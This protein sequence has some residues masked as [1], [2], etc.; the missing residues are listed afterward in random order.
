MPYRPPTGA[1]RPPGTPWISRNTSRQR[2][3]RG[4]KA[5]RF[6]LHRAGLPIRCGSSLP[7]NT[8]G[9]VWRRMSFSTCSAGALPGPDFCFIFAPYGYDEPETFPSESPSIC[10][11]GADGKQSHTIQLGRGKPHGAD[12]D[13]NRGKKSNDACLLGKRRCVS[14]HSKP[15]RIPAQWVRNRDFSSS[16]SSRSAR[17]IS[18]RTGHHWSNFRYFSYAS[19][20]GFGWALG[21]FAKR[22]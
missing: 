5:Q 10:L 17:P 14:E 1:C 2:C 13:E 21:A 9:G 8:T 4:G 18:S 20:V 19:P 22:R 12:P 6:S 11:R 3:P 16:L 15:Q 7:L